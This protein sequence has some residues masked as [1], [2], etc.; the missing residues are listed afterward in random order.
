MKTCENRKSR[1][2]SFESRTTLRHHLSTLPSSQP[3]PGGNWSQD[4]SQDELIPGQERRLQ[5]QPLC[6]GTS[7]SNGQDSFEQVKL[8][9]TRKRPVKGQIIQKISDR[10]P[11]VVVAKRWNDQRQR[12][13]CHGLRALGTHARGGGHVLEPSRSSLAQCDALTRRRR[14]H[15]VLSLTGFTDSNSHPSRESRLL[16]VFRGCFACRR[17]SLHEK[18][19][20][21]IQANKTQNV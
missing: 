9:D 14:G 7:K 19:D 8:R 4:N 13:Q 16:F 3:V 2:R 1:R 11:G 6:R 17:T 21:T 18:I 5:A 20:K 10:F 15:C 12:R